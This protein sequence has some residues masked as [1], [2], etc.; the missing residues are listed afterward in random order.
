MRPKLRTTM[1]QAM[2]YVGAL[3]CALF[4]LVPFLWTLAMSLKNARDVTAIPPLLWFHPTLQNYAALFSNQAY[5][6]IAHSQIDFTRVLTNSLIESG[7]AVLISLLLSFP[8]A[9]ALA[10]MRFRFRENVAVTILS[11]YFA[12]PLAL[13]L[14]LFEIYQ[15]LHLYNTVP[16]MILVDQVICLP[17]IIW[18]L[19]S[20]F[21]EIPVEIEEAAKIDGCT[22][23]QL[24]SVILWPI[25]RPAVAATATLAFIFCWNNFLFG[26]LLSSTQTQPIATAAISFISYQQVLWGQMSAA[27]IL[28]VIPE[29]VLAL[30]TQRYLVR[31]L[32]FG[33]IQ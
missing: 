33:A 20:Y 1:T 7:T 31:G 15:A 28:A 27:A 23:R 3:A 4:V 13:A 18:V 26:Y 17:L 19:R 12:P 22:L 24:L 29:F 25:T 16:G 30:L 14:P 6:A 5:S 9:Y 2:V 32:S 11:F 8:C 10:R 21:E